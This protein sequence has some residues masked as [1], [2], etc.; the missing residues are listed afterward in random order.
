MENLVENNSHKNSPSSDARAVRRYRDESQGW[1]SAWEQGKGEGGVPKG[2]RGA[3]Q[4]RITS[5]SE[6]ELPSH[7]SA[8]FQFHNH[9]AFPGVRS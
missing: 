7:A 2:G 9:H 6:P 8:A 1:R 4:H 3:R 5:R